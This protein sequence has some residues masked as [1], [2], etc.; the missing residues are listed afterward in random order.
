[1]NE[2]IILIAHGS[3]DPKWKKP[4][5]SLHESL[6]ETFGEEKI[7]LCYME[8]INPNLEEIIISSIKNKITNF[9][10]I[11][12]FMAGGGHVD[13]DIPEQIAGAKEKFPEIKISLLPS[14]GENPIVIK[15]FKEVISSQ[16]K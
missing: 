16:F 12:L 14:I 11:P 10:I 13:R 3:K 1:M 8:F 15:A 9:K 7:G 4:F 2:K 6:K 5:E